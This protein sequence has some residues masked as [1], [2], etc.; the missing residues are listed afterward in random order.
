MLKFSE[1]WKEVFKT[2]THTDA[3]G[4]TRE[5][6]EGD[7]DEIVTKYNQQVADKKH[8]APVVIGHP[9]N[10]SPAY[11]WVESLKRIGSTLLAKF[12]DVDKQFQ[13]LVNQGRYQKISIALYPDKLLRHVGFLGAVPPAVKGLKA[14][15]FNDADQ[16]ITKLEYEKP[17]INYSEANMPVQIKNLFSDLLNGISSKYNSE[18]ANQIKLDIDVLV[19]KHNINV[20]QKPDN[21][22]PPKFT[23][24]PEYKEFQEKMKRLEADYSKL[25]ADNREMKFNEI[26]ATHFLNKGKGGPAAKEQMRTIYNLYQESGK[27]FEYKEGDAT[28][29]LTGEAAFIKFLE[30][31]PNVIEFNEIAGKG[32]VSGADFSEDDK[33]IEEYNKSRGGR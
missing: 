7:L 4:N 8:D 15:T 30:S 17:I 31:L 24:A 11:A 12:R 19:K 33:I 23:E 25:V 16:A 26:F 18:L 27:S 21:P 28:V 32:N 9:V 29:N 2:G 1:I 20:D 22:E 10:N 13:D 14:P 3:A 6:T 5:W